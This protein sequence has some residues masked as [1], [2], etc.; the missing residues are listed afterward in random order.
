MP[1]CH[2]TLSESLKDPNTNEIN[3]IRDIVA[4]ELLSDARYLDRNH[5]VIR[6]QRS[7]LC[8][9]LGEVEIEIF[10]QDDSQRFS[11]R[12]ERAKNISSQVSKLLKHDCATWINLSNV[13]Y[14]RVTTTGQEY[15]SD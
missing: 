7:K 3:I 10:A 12:D 13:G 14:C 5:I 8:F 15:F 6:I 9:M 2:I 4:K 11:S 1:V